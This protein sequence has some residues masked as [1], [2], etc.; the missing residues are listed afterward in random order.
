ML[1]SH[2][3]HL[4][5]ASSL[6]LPV[7][8]VFTYLKSWHTAYVVS[9]HSFTRVHLLRGGAFKTKFDHFASCAESLTFVEGIGLISGS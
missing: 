1:G 7:V 4:P 2:C 9:M 8:P 6:L 3:C 5:L